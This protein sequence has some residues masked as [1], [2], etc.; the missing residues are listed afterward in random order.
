MCDDLSAELEAMS[1]A[2]FDHETEDLKGDFWDWLGEYRFVPTVCVLPYSGA[3]LPPGDIMYIEE[4]F[5]KERYRGEP[6]HTAARH[7][8]TVLRIR[9]RP[10]SGRLPHFPDPQLCAAGGHPCALSLQSERLRTRPIRR[11]ARS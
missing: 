10:T 6:T 1:T 3:D 11:F 4:I 5:V 9:Y 2:L 8:L 7:T